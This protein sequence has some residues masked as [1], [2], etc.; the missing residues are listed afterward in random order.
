MELE[1]H[2]FEAERDRP[3]QSWRENE[4]KNELAEVEESGRRDKI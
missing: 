2:I 1:G 4:L 3:R